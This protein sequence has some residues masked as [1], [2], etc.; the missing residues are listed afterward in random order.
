MSK[1]PS[2]TSR[3]SRPAVGTVKNLVS[4]INSSQAM[5]PTAASL[6]RRRSSRLAREEA[7]P[8]PRRISRAASLAPSSAA[9]STGLTTL[10]SEANVGEALA[11]DDGE[12]AAEE[13]EAQVEEAEADAE[14]EQEAEQEQESEQE[15]AA[16]PPPRFPPPPA[17]RRKAA[18]AAA[19]GVDALASQFPAPPSGRT[20]RRG[21]G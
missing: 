13:A 7:A 4:N 20:A 19:K 17:D 9:S 15:P 2:L 16:P 10:L 6:M 3:S 5:A 8:Y 18:S 14:E 11:W 21:R 1:R 12:A